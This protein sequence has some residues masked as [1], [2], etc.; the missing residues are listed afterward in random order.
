MSQTLTPINGGT[1]KIQTTP[2]SVSIQYLSPQYIE[3]ESLESRPT[4]WVPGGRPIYNRLPAVSQTYRTDF[5]YDENKGYVLVFP[6]ESTSGPQ[7]LQLISSEDKKFL[8]VKGG[9][10]VWKYGQTAVEP[11]IIDLEAVG[12]QST[13]YFIGYQLYYDNAPIAGQYEVSDFYLGG[14]PLTINSS[15]DS[16]KGWRYSPAN[17]FVESERV[18]KNSDNVLPTYV[19]P[20]SAY[21]SWESA[22]AAYSKIVLRCPASGKFSG[23]ASLSY[24]VGN[25]WSY[26]QTTNIQTDSTS[27]YFEFVIDSP[28]FQ[29]GWKVTW[30]DLSVQ[31]NE[32]K[33]SGI[34][35]VETQ[36]STYR[37][38]SNLVAWPA[39]TVPTSFKNSLGEDIPLIFCGLG[40]IDVD[41]QFRVEKITDIRET[42]NTG[43]QPVADWLTRPWDE[44]LIQNFEQV[45]GYPEL[46]MSPQNAM[47]QEYLALSSDSIQVVS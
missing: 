12:L 38:Q 6:G 17:V 19:Q 46:W 24:K 26:V 34:V 25:N 15:T 8:I 18:W 29:E 20:S 32:V 23:Q 35:T 2:S 21:L 14:L 5:N 16:V 45:S 10:I 30:T 27:Q 22:L 3:T 37:P 7:T 44:D 36:P 41:S 33:V 28:S 40:Y 42:V 47:K 43:F 39:N 11:V 9:S 4:Q 31:V 1:T 13:R